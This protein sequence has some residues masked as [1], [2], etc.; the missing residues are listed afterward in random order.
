MHGEPESV[1][2]RLEQLLI[3]CEWF[4]LPVLATFE[5]PVEAKGRLPERLDRVFPAE[6]LTFSKQAFAITGEPQITTAIKQLGRRQLAVAGA[7]TD[8]CILQS[9]LGL[10]SLDYQVFLLQDCLFSSEPQ[11]SPAL[12]RMY[13]AGAIPCT[14]KMLF[15]ELLETNDP[16]PW[17]EQQQRA[18]ERGF[19]PPESMPPST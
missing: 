17:L 3:S 1:L 10:I 5:E 2:D 4:Q 7:E 11:V 6:G 18:V 19:Q 16:A 13:A 15:Y 14:Y 8:V 9:V 12:S